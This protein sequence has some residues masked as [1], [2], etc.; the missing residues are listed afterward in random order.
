MNVPF[1]LY[2]LHNSGEFIFLKE[3]SATAVTRGFPPKVVPWSPGLNDCATS[4]VQSIAPNGRPP[5][6]A[7]GHCQNVWY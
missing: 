3:A 2:L 1:F 4:S 5:P 7:F 6:S